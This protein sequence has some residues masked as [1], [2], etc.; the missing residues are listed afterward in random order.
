MVR[1]FLDLWSLE[2]SELR[3]ILDDAHARKAAR[4][5]FSK[6]RIDNHPAGAGRTLAMIFEKNSTRTRFSFD[7]AMRQ[8]GGASIISTSSD[9]QLGRGETIEDTARV[10]SRMVDAVMIRTHGH[11]RVTA[12]AAAS[13]IPVINGLSEGGHPCQIIADL[14]TLEEHRGALAGKVIAWVGDGNNVC[15]SFIQAAPKFGFEL[16]VATPEA[17]APDAVDVA[18]AREAQGRINLTRDPREAV[19]GA[20]CV[21]ADTFVSMGDSDGEERLAAL[22]PYQVNAALM[23]VA[24]AKAVFL[25]CLPAHRG[26][27]V[28]DEVIDGPASLV[29]DEAENRIHAQKSILA[30]CFGTLPTG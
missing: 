18:R 2:A 19:D 7:A 22:D 21:V 6:G 23:A 13:S 12:F 4:K 29:W 24:G 25:H 14:Q 17:Y 1:H 20:D 27:E 11:E 16:R 10:L 8:L 15:S 26:E 30:W 28:T 5:G 3:A 9:M